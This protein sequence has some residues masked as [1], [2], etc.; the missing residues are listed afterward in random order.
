MHKSLHTKEVAVPFQPCAAAPGPAF[1]KQL[2]WLLCKEIAELN[3]L[4]TS[5][6]LQC[7]SDVFW[8]VSLLVVTAFLLQH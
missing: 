8:L 2:T 3:I 1:S 4:F 6:L 5:T 7:L